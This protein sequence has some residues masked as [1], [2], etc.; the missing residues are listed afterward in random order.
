MSGKIENIL[1]SQVAPNCITNYLRSLV[2]MSQNTNNSVHLHQT[3]LAMRCY[4]HNNASVAEPVPTR[5][6]LGNVLRYSE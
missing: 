6:K 5:E 2:E 1:L 4:V 3:Q